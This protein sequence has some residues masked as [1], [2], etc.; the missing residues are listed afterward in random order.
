MASKKGVSALRVAGTYIGTVV[1]AGF[2][3]GQEV[4]QFFV[5]F[6]NAGIA[7]LLVVTVLFMVL[8]F[9]VMET[10]NRVHAESHLDIVEATSGRILS[11]FSDVIISFF[12]FGTLSAMFA[13]SGALISQRFG[14]H[15]FSGGLLMAVLTT[16]TV[17]SGFN[18]TINSI[19][20]VV[21]FLLVSA[22]GT[23]I[24]SLF[25]EPEKT[26]LRSFAPN[27]GFLRNWFWSAIL[28]TSYNTVISF[29]IL[30]PLGA[31]AKN[32]K[33]ILYGAILGGLGLGIGAFA[34]FFSI[35]HHFTKAAGMEVPMI[36]I[37]GRVSPAAGIIYGIVL[38]A[39]IYT[40]AVGNL[41]GLSARISASVPWNSRD[42][43]VISALCA[44]LI[45]LLGFSNLVRYLYPSVGYAGII[46]LTS[47]VINRKNSIDKK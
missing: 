6:G 29:S 3:S 38:L 1:G 46:T 28:Y 21:P 30:G 26:A 15:P 9:M 34:L 39:E 2:A 31:R 41:Y 24:L 14:L 10:G 18:G 33:A 45:S 7:G 35:R 11:V 5:C 4:L 13:G 22:V 19:S 44:F 23:G 43:T 17:L 27:T 32:R 40:T 25:I 12:L 36:Y 16:L 8:G 47:L 20:L 37:A 42:I